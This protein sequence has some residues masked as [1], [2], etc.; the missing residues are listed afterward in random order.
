MSARRAR[1][2][3]PEERRHRGHA[4]QRGS[5]SSRVHDD[6]DAPKRRGSRRPTS[7]RDFFSCLPGATS[8]APN[9]RIDNCRWVIDGALFDK[10]ALTATAG[11]FSLEGGADGTVPVNPIPANPQEPDGADGRPPGPTSSR[12]PLRPRAPTHADRQHRGSSA[13]L[14]RGLCKRSAQ[15][16]R[17]QLPRRQLDGHAWQD[18]DGDKVDIIKNGQPYAQYVMR[19]VWKKAPTRP[20]RSEAV[21][22]TRS[23]ST[24]DGASARA[25]RVPV[26]AA[27]VPDVAV[28][29]R[30]LLS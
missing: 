4:R 12:R 17:L 26:D 25:G 24:S 10:I 1:R 22:Q 14:P 19:I 20:P 15:R 9:S 30:D 7:E 21:S 28:R 6:K 8:S 2:R 13:D 29:C 5:G 3:G 18:D 16:G 27:L 23:S 11:Q